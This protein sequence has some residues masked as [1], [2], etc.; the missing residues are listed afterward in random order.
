V[1]HIHRSQI[2]SRGPREITAEITAAFDKL[3]G[4]AK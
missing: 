2:E 3:C 4:V 1:Y